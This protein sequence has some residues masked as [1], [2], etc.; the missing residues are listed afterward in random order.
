MTH[1]EISGVFAGFRAIFRGIHENCSHFNPKTS[2]NVT[3]VTHTCQL[4]STTRAANT[5]SPAYF[6]VTDALLGSAHAP[7]PHGLTNRFLATHRPGLHDTPSPGLAPSV[8]RPP[9]ECSA[10]ARSPRS[11]PLRAPVV[12]PRVHPARREHTPLPTLSPALPHPRRSDNPRDY[13]A[14]AHDVHPLTH[15]PSVPTRNSARHTF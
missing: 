11:R 1:Y 14:C 12:M 10:C 5:R 9:T 13:A 2:N 3:P 4:F 15:S 6:S 8:S 7:S